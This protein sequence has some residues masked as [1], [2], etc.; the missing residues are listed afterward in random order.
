[1]TLANYTQNNSPIKVKIIAK[2]DI[3]PITLAS[4]GAHRCY[5]PGEPDIDAIMNVEDPF[6]SGHLTLF[7]MS[8]YTF[9]IRDIP[10]SSVIF[11]LHA[12]AGYYITAQLSGR[13]SSMYENR[14]MRA[15]ENIIYSYYPELWAS[16]VNRITDFIKF[17]MD[18]YQDSKP[19]IDELARDAIKTERPYAS[20]KDINRNAP[21]FAQEQLR[22][23]ISMIAPT[24]LDWTVNLSAINGFYRTAHTGPMRDVIDQIVRLVEQDQ[25][26][27]AN[28]NPKNAGKNTDDLSF[29]FGESVRSTEDWTPS[30]PGYKGI[31][32]A[33]ECKLIDYRYD[34]AM[35]CEINPRDMVDIWSFSPKTK[36]NSCMDI[37][38]H[39]VEDAGATY[40]QNIRHRTA[41]RSEPK[42]TGHFYLPPLLDAANL[43]PAAIEFMQRY[44]ELYHDPKFPKSLMT[45]IAP[46]GLMVEY[47]EKLPL[48]SFIHKMG[49]RTCGCAQ[50]A[51]RYEALSLRQQIKE[52]MGDV[53]LLQCMTPRCV[54]KGYCPEGKRCCGQGI[55]NVVAAMQAEHIQRHRV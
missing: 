33:P 48:N 30:Y 19:R 42:F 8:Y 21:K 7:Q 52:Q 41:D 13:F 54:S 34:D 37:L 55:S 28:R 36:N 24:S 10:V 27:R 4:H 45:M 2:T 25:K 26:D 12:T 44:D 3:D 31:K 51:V 46:Y 18:V 11:G 29:M 43:K 1:M 40:G 35:F 6:D 23:F 50:E 38:T 14:D 39:V 9:H 20:D 47:D 53:R 15:I 49:K 5:H 22:M 16:D 32:T 17:G